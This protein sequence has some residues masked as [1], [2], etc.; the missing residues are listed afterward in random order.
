MPPGR[1]SRTRATASATSPPTAATS[2]TVALPARHGP[3]RRRATRKSMPSGAQ[4]VGTPIEPSGR[5]SRCPWTTTSEAPEAVTPDSVSHLLCCHRATI[6]CVEED[7]TCAESR[8]ATD[9]CFR[10]NAGARALVSDAPA[11]DE[12]RPSLTTMSPLPQSLGKRARADPQSKHSEL[13]QFSSELRSRERPTVTRMP[14]GFVPCSASARRA[15][16]VPAPSA[17]SRLGLRC[18]RTGSW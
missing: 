6:E 10:A 16:P 7:L 5:G 2:P 11:A 18:F 13:V 17:R 4:R 12:H 8:A 3:T 14:I 1:R 15:W 9:P